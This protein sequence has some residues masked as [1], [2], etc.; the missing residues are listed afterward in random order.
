MIVFIYSSGHLSKLISRK[1]LSYSAKVLSDMGGSCWNSSLN[2]PKR[3]GLWAYFSTSEM[4]EK[5][6]WSATSLSY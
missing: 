6:E 1:K 3:L 5:R 2:N 4:P